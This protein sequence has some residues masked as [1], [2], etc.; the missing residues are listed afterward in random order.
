MW[1]PSFMFLGGRLM[2]IG[3]FRGPMEG[4]MGSL[5]G[6]P[7]REL[8]LDSPGE[9][10]GDGTCSSSVERK[11]VR[12]GLFS[13]LSISF[14]SSS[15]TLKVLHYV[16]DREWPWDSHN[17]YLPQKRKIEKATEGWRSRTWEQGNNINTRICMSKKP[18]PI[19]SHLYQ[20]LRN[21]F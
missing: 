21:C 7:S 11:W 19:P 2:I 6:E 14:H 1:N 10:I 4:D 8:V 18:N 12:W 5:E 17:L 15:V 13:C 9:F 3:G 20:M 16:T